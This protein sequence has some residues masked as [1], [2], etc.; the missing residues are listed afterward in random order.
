MPDGRELLG[1]HRLDPG[2]YSLSIAACALDATSNMSKG[3]ETYMR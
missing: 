3:G 2:K 1:T